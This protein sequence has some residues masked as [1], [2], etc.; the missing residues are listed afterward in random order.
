MLNQKVGNCFIQ[1]TQPINQKKRNHIKM[2][3]P[4]E[5]DQIDDWGDVRLIKTTIYVFVCVCK[6]SLVGW[7]T[8]LSMKLW[9]LTQSYNYLSMFFSYQHIYIQL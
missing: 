3:A 1:E 7:K 9:V 4:A 2:L 5:V 6:S 8:V